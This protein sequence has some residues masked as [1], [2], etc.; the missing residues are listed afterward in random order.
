MRTRKSNSGDLSQGSQGRPSE[1]L[2]S[3]ATRLGLISGIIVALIGG[4]ATILAAVVATHRSI[5]APHPAAPT[6]AQPEAAVPLTTC[7][8]CT[9]SKTIHQ[10]PTTGSSTNCLHPSRMPDTRTRV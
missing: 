4:T 1:D 7:A 3:G 9:S 8:T 6:T 2:A 10:P 5:T